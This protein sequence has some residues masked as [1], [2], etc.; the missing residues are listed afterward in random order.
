MILTLDGFSDL[1]DA[2]EIAYELCAPFSG[3]SITINL[4]KGDHYLLDAYRDYYLP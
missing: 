3:C 2:I 1:E 4:K